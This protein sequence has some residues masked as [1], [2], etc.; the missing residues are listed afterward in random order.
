MEGADGATATAMGLLRLAPR[1]EREAAGPEDEGKIHSSPNLRIHI[2]SAQG[3]QQVVQAREAYVMHLWQG[4]GGPSQ[5]LRETQ[6]STAL[7]RLSALRTV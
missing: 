1:V 5:R 2:S 7:E 4:P 3:F 6:V